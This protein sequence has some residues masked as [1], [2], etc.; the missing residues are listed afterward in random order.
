MLQD[1][2]HSEEK[3]N[4]ILQ[5]YVNTHFTKMKP[6]CSDFKFLHSINHSKENKENHSEV[7]IRNGRLLLPHFFHFHVLPKHH[8]CR[9]EQ[10]LA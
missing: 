9:N 3:A 6:A 4:N 5:N 1:I 2:F 7:K 10:F 8:L